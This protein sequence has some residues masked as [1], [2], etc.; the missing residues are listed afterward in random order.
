[1][2]H[3]LFVAILGLRIGGIAALWLGGLWSCDRDSG[4]TPLAAH[5]R[6]TARRSARSPHIDSCAIFIGMS[7]SQSRRRWCPSDIARARHQVVQLVVD[8][9]QRQPGQPAAHDG[10]PVPNCAVAPAASA[11]PRPCNF[12]GWC[13]RTT[14]NGR[15]PSG[16]GRLITKLTPLPRRAV[17]GF[18][19]GGG[20]SLEPL[21]RVPRRRLARTAHMETN[22]PRGRCSRGQ[23]RP[24]IASSQVCRKDCRS[25]TNGCR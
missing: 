17:T 7:A 4:I 3:S 9:G 8:G 16:S 19:A 5:P 11:C 1:M 6:E 25:G 10:A 15:V 2:V 14:K 12:F 21:L 23:A 13:R 20:P 18:P 24:S 22:I